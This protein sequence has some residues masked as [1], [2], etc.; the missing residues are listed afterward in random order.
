MQWIRDA[1]PNFSSIVR[2]LLESLKRVYARA[3][4][5]T[6]IAVA[7]VSLHSL[8]WGITEA[9]S[10]NECKNAFHNQVT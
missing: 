10:F 5:R 4:K 6:K 7:K 8:S 2:P 3:I 9:D 1:I